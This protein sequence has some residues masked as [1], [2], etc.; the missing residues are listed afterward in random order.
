M[1]KG[2]EGT[3]IVSILMYVVVFLLGM[4]I[5]L[6]S[7]YCQNNLSNITYP[8]SG[9]DLAKNITWNCARSSNYDATCVATIMDNISYGNCNDYS[10][11]TYYDC[12]VAAGEPCTII[13]AFGNKS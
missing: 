2:I 13:E 12:S 10:N 4:S 8:D 7:K 3:T 6:S 11:V 9:C 5:A 1:K